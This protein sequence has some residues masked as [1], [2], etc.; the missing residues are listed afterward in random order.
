VAIGDQRP[1]GLAFG[2]FGEQTGENVVGA[3]PG[4]ADQVFALRVEV[5]QIRREPG[6]LG[7]ELGDARVLNHDELPG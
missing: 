7:E 2:Q 3:T 5:Q 6:V 1:P 4:K